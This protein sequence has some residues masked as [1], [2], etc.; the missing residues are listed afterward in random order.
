MFIKRK[1]NYECKQILNC[2][3]SDIFDVGLLYEVY[4]KIRI[5]EFVGGGGSDGGIQS[6]FYFFV[7]VIEYVIKFVLWYRE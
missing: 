7:W 1:Y 4:Y 3:K 5:L 6:Y 2:F